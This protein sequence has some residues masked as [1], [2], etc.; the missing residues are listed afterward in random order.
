MK[1]GVRITNRPTNGDT[2]PSAGNDPTV[3]LHTDH[4]PPG[5]EA[6]FTAGSDACRHKVRSR[7]IAR[8]Q[9]DKY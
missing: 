5:W 2:F 4:S 8:R 9:I 1:I 6:G 7:L 3:F